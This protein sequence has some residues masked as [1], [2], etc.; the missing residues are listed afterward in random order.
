MES[1]AAE[2][3]NKI[4]KQNPQLPQK[5]SPQVS[6]T[7]PFIALNTDERILGLRSQMPAGADNL[8][9]AILPASMCF[10]NIMNCEP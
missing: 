4:G 10:Q 7:A 8:L 3:L 1:I 9:K 6:A 5:P 2:R